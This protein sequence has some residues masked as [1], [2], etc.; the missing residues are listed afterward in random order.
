MNKGLKEISKFISLILRHKP[1][2]I[3]VDMD[4]NGWINID[5]MIEGINKSGYKLDRETLY[6]II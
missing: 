5:K 3:N 4:N 2:I 6:Y 1:E